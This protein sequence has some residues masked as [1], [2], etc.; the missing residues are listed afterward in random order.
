MKT[1]YLSVTLLS[2]LLT[3][4][5]FIGDIHTHAQTSVSLYPIG[6]T[7]P[8]TNPTQSSAMDVGNTTHNIYN[9]GATTSVI[10]HRRTHIVHS[11]APSLSRRQIVGRYNQIYKKQTSQPGY[12]SSGVS[13]LTITKRRNNTLATLHLAADDS[14]GNDDSSNSPGSPANPGDTP[15]TTSE[16]S[17]CNGSLNNECHALLLLALVFLLLQ[18]N[19]YKMTK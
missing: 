2:L 13:T 17:I 4:S 3:F 19:R 15:A 6:I 16:Q 5:N 8:Q 14:D 10:S 1:T 12:T 18:R 9:I 7:S 11:T